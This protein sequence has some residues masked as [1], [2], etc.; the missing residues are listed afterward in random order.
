M[1]EKN[2][3]AVDM[4]GKVNPFSIKQAVFE[5][6]E[7]CNKFFVQDCFLYGFPNQN[8]EKLWNSLLKWKYVDTIIPVF[9]ICPFL[10]II[11]QEYKFLNEKKLMLK[12]NL[13]DHNPRF[14]S[15]G[16][17]VFN[18]ESNPLNIWLIN[19]IL[20]VQ[21][22]DNLYIFLRPKLFK[23][24][25]LVKLWRLFIPSILG[26]NNVRKVKKWQ[27]LFKNK[28]FPMYILDK[29]NIFEFETSILNP[30]FI[31]NDVP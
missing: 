19:K 30:S 25:N 22:I 3:I 27:F 23:R 21:I 7:Y 6:L 13:L 15:F 16:K 24:E 31:W 26:T 5:L 4:V 10:T 9:D 17:T 20:P 29:N 12:F 1:A 8:I 14:F 11:F 18:I 28:S 2:N